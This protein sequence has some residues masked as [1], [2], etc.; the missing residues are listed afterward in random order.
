VAPL[1]CRYNK[2]GYGARRY[3]V[4]FKLMLRSLQTTEYALTRCRYGCVNSVFEP[5][6][7]V[8][9]DERDSRAHTFYYEGGIESF[10]FI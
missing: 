6:R 9:E 4:T 3:H 7:I 5:L 8:I 10:V 2:S 1:R